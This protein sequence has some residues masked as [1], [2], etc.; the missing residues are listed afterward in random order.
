MVQAFN[1]YDFKIDNLYKHKIRI[2]I[3][4]F[5]KNPFFVLKVYIKIV[6]IIKYKYHKFIKK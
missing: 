5:I 1:N 2:N 6:L 3:V 4:F